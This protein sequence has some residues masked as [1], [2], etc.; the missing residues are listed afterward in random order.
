ME[1]I[2]SNLCLVF[3]QFKT[4]V[5]G[6]ESV[7]MITEK[8]GATHLIDTI[9]IPSDGGPMDQIDIYVGRP[10][11]MT[12]WNVK[13]FFHFNNLFTDR[14]WAY[15]V[16]I[17]VGKNAASNIIV[18]IPQSSFP[19]CVDIFASNGP[20]LPMPTEMVS[21]HQL[22]AACASCHAPSK[23][24]CLIPRVGD[25]HRCQ[26]GACVPRIGPELTNASMAMIDRMILDVS[27]FCPLFQHLFYSV[28]T[29][30][31]VIRSL[32]TINRQLLKRFIQSDASIFRRDVVKEANFK[33]TVTEFQ[34][35]QFSNGALKIL[36]KSVGKDRIRFA[37]PNKSDRSKAA[38]GKMFPTFGAAS[39]WEIISLFNSA[40]GSPGDVFVRDLALWDKNLVPIASRLMMMAQVEDVY[41]IFILVGWA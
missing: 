35:V 31:G 20:L 13:R 28:A 39:P 41:N 27:V 24:G 26:P 36:D 6:F 37:V 40:L 32:P 11:D 1:N 18:D 5:L 2:M 21:A 10:N 23:C 14:S 7:P 9:A 22:T 17:M 16:V 29:I 12:L 4:F 30:F 38:V 33:T 3:L 8:F 19:W 15:D 34:L 25:C